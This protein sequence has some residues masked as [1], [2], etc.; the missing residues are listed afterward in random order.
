MVS[1]ETCKKYTN[2]LII[3]KWLDLFE[4]CGYTLVRGRSPQICDERIKS[5][6]LVCLLADV[7]DL[8]AATHGRMHPQQLLLEFDEDS[9]ENLLK[10]CTPAV[11][12]S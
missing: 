7:K 5:W 2:T 11:Y 12:F 1:Y 3:Y 6:Q 8:D 4:E 9:L 10:W